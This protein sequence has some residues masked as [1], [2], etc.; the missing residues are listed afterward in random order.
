MIISDTKVTTTLSKTEAFKIQASGKAFQ[1]LS[2]NLYKNKYAAII[3]ELSCNAYDSHV[4]AGKAD[5]P[6]LIE[7][8]GLIRPVLAIEDFGVGLSE[9]AVK[10]IYTT[11]FES[12]K[13]ESNEVIGGFGLGSKTPFAY[14]KTFTIIAT[15]DGIRNT[16]IAYIGEQGVPVISLM[17]T[18]KGE[19]DNGVRIEIPV[20]KNDNCMFEEELKQ[21][22][23]FKTKPI[24]RRPNGDE[25]ELN[26]NV[27]IDELETEGVTVLPHF[28]RR[29]RTDLFAVMG[30]VR[31]P[32]NSDLLND[33][34]VYKQI[35]NF[36]GN[37]DVYIRFDIGEIDIAVSREELSYDK[38]TVECL[39]SRLTESLIKIQAGYNA[40]WNQA[41]KC[42]HEKFVE[43]DKKYKRYTDSQLNGLIAIEMGKHIPKDSPYWAHARSQVSI[44]A[45]VSMVRIN[46]QSDRRKYETQSGVLPSQCIQWLIPNTYYRMPGHVVMIEGD[47]KLLRKEWLARYTDIKP[48]YKHTSF[49]LCNDWSNTKDAFLSVF[50]RDTK[51]ITIDELKDIVR[52]HEKSM[53]ET[54]TNTSSRP[55]Y[56]KDRI[57]T[58][59]NRELFLDN[60]PKNT[61]FCCTPSADFSACYLF[62]KP[63]YP[64]A[65]IHNIN[66]SYRNRVLAAGHKILNEDRPVYR[67]TEEEVLYLFKQILSA[68]GS[69]EAA[70]DKLTYL[71]RYTLRGYLLSEHFPK[72]YMWEWAT[73]GDY[74]EFV[75][76]NIDCLDILDSLTYNS[77][78]E[79]KFNWEWVYHY[80]C[81]HFTVPA[82]NRATEK[83]PVLL[84]LENSI[85]D[86]NQRKVFDNIIN[87]RGDI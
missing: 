56:P 52:E 68:C 42:F 4:M 84:L 75:T 74:E 49:F 23:L 32:I 58:K 45:Q 24:I 17:N 59:N 37:A 83:Y 48:E 77:Q 11:Y 82:I 15:K 20:D 30:Q 65:E 7:L 31:Y 63:L 33:K 55:T 34:Q 60:L 70:R 78:I 57:L 66:S 46:Y 87:Q 28:I 10:S 81:K 73:I 21:L 86:D 5:V 29:F 27:D 41:D 26:H 44:S 19:F 51:I 39:Q 16:F 85:V 80:V 14:T 43:S 53:V 22:T 13:T 25:V 67:Y 38:E 18:S 72:Y 6:F 3:R 8:P 79:A 54:S 64:H 47:L 69:K 40:I 9:E 71:V 50:P 76:N 61:M 62:F 35:S 12:T 1:I 2:S 36:V